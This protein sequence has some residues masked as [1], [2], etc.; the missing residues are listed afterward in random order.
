MASTATTATK[1]AASPRL[2]RAARRTP[3]VPAPA[4]APS[5]LS[6][7]QAQHSNQAERAQVGDR[8]RS[9]CL[10]PGEAPSV[11]SSS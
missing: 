7:S 5:G 8:L 2:R 4:A 6:A 3:P 10:Q 11:P 9:L 1:Q